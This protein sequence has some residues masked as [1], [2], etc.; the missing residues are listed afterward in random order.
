MFKYVQSNIQ[1]I[2]SPNHIIFIKPYKTDKGYILIARKDNRNIPITYPKNRLTFPTAPIYWL[3]REMVGQFYWEDFA[4][5]NNKI[6]VN[7]N[8]I[9]RL[10]Y[11]EDENSNLIEVNIYF[12]N[13]NELVLA[14]C[15][16]KQFFTK[17]KQE[18]ENLFGCKIQQE[19]KTELR[20]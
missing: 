15:S 1:N 7:K 4:I 13:R 5:I 17:L 3:A 10:S 8:Y 9:L 19:F 11:T 18:F 14:R 20:K 2:K 6:A 16:K 12:T